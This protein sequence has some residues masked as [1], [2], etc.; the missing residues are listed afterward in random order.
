[1]SNLGIGL[2]SAG[3]D[4]QQGYFDPNKKIKTEDTSSGDEARSPEPLRKYKKML[5][6]MYVKIE[7]LNEKQK[8][9]CT[10]VAPRTVLAKKS[11]TSSL[12]AKKADKTMLSKKNP[13]PK[14]PVQASSAISS[15]AD[16]GVTK[17][18]K[19]SPKKITSKSS[20][21]LETLPSLGKNRKTGVYTTSSQSSFTSLKSVNSSVKSNSIVNGTPSV[22]RQKNQTDTA[23]SLT[24][25]DLRYIIGS[26]P[27]PLKMQANG[28]LS[29]DLEESSD[30]QEDMDESDNFDSMSIHADDDDLF[31]NTGQKEDLNTLGK[32]FESSANF[33]PQHETTETRIM[34]ST[35]RKRPRSNIE[36]NPRQLNKRK[37]DAARNAL[38]DLEKSTVRETPAGKLG[39]S[40]TQESKPANS[41]QMDDEKNGLVHGLAHPSHL[42]GESSKENTVSCSL[43]SRTSNGAMV[44]GRGMNTQNIH[45]KRSSRN[46]DGR[47]FPSQ[48]RMI[49]PPQSLGYV[50]PRMNVHGQ[51]VLGPQNPYLSCPPNQMR[52]MR[53]NFH[54]NQNRHRFLA[55]Q[56][57]LCWLDSR[58]FHQQ[59]FDPAMNNRRIPPNFP[60]NCIPL[61]QAFIRDHRSVGCNNLESLMRAATEEA[62]NLDTKVVF[63]L[64]EQ[65]RKE[66][67]NRK[68]NQLD[69]SYAIEALVSLD[70]INNAVALVL[71]MKQNDLKPRQKDLKNIRNGIC[72]LSSVDSTDRLVGFFDLLDL[73]DLANKRVVEELVKHVPAQEVK[74]KANRERIIQM[75][76]E[77]TKEQSFPVSPSFQPHIPVFKDLTDMLV[78][79]IDQISP[80]QDIPVDLVKQLIESVN[81]DQNAFI[82]TT[83]LSSLPKEILCNVDCEVWNDFLRKACSGN[84]QI[85]SQIQGIMVNLGIPVDSAV[86]LQLLC[87]FHKAQFPK[88]ALE[89]VENV[90][91]EELASADVNDDVYECL[92]NIMTQPLIDNIDSCCKIVMIMIKFG[93]MPPNDKLREIMNILKGLHRYQEIYDLINKLIE[94]GLKPSEEN[95][96][97]ALSALED[98]DE[99]PGAFAELYK[100]TRKYY[101]KLRICSDSMAMHTA[102]DTTEEFVTYQQPEAST[103]AN[104]TSNDASRPVPLDD[105]V[106][107]PNTNPFQ[108]LMSM[109]KADKYQANDPAKAMIVRIPSANS[110]EA[111]VISKTDSGY[112]SNGS[113]GCVTTIPSRSISFDTSH[114][115]RQIFDRLALASKSNDI[116]TVC[117]IYV[118]MRESNIAIDDRALHQI[119]EAIAKNNPVCR[120]EQL[121]N[122]VKEQITG[123]HLV[124]EEDNTET[125]GAPTIFRDEDQQNLGRLAVTLLF[126]LM[127]KE[128]P[129]EAFELL[130]LLHQSQVNY[131]VFG[132]SF[133]EN[134]NRTNCQIVMTAL[135]VCLL[136]SP[137]QVDD[138]MTVF[139]GTDYGRPVTTVEDEQERTSVLLKLTEDLLSVGKFDDAD[140]VLNELDIELAKY[141][142][143]LL[144]RLS[145]ENNVQ[146]AAKV[147]QFMDTKKHVSKEPRSF[148]AYLNCLARRSHIAEAKT[149][150]EVGRTL[151]IYPC[152]ERTDPYFFE[153]PCNL[154]PIEMLF[155]L[156]EHLKRIQKTAL[157]GDGKIKPLMSQTAF[158]VIFKDNYE[159]FE[160]P[161]E[162]IASAREKMV[163]VLSEMMKPP[164]K[165]V[166]TE[167]PN[168]VETY[169]MPALPY[170]TLPF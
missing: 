42:I 99:N 90:N 54:N 23:S 157:Y 143:N 101:P 145:E 70:D 48:P 69:Y 166:E 165:I 109:W 22:A 133:D 68:L 142:N 102:N 74:Q 154:T 161:H 104:S 156:E 123:T 83:K 98:W 4:G 167:N 50:R 64:L 132:K 59:N 10:S 106:Q 97:L 36:D 89:V 116:Q 26:K 80:L 29:T 153:L 31:D 158:K 46:A 129:S 147:Y 85:A 141:L 21:N 11:A 27:N 75:V 77:I 40:A 25:D 43:G 28:K 56:V 5:K 112:I 168:E 140:E 92:T 14:R 114:D 81:T 122:S 3:A 66:R 53:A 65:L 148:R 58:Q 137:P 57:I 93:K 55:L 120:L 71:E 87:C 100:A 6:P 111:E 72:T 84:L 150:F 91:P 38:N 151:E 125:D 117:D 47:G 128:R 113:A 108:E 2:T 146:R 60:E 79:K 149:I 76:E 162:Q 134:P 139:R 82:V 110:E 67:V 163:I 152:Q 95:F 61:C 73:H 39:S 15:S 51:N 96:F 19:S 13:A 49:S 160:T 119:Y 78:A 7:P 118:E 37:P 124:L 12:V 144:L 107:L 94:A 18:S 34:N 30:M 9:K 63:F 105:A 32:H 164:L 121:L 131:F 62:V 169:P 127:E 103:L 44:K 41:V 17:I 138:A 1:M 88:E 130:F 20:K 45:N 155:M 159:L 16:I 35:L 170:P 136:L 86:A 8:A 33:E 52:M 126:E 24:P 135:K 115:T